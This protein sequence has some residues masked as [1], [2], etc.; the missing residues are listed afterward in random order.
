MYTYDEFIKLLCEHFNVFSLIN[1]KRIDKEKIN[2]DNLTEKFEIV[3]MDRNVSITTSNIQ[4]LVTPSEARAIPEFLEDIDLI[5]GEEERYNFNITVSDG[6]VFIKQLVADSLSIN[7]SDGDVYLENCILGSLSI[8]M[9]DGDT[10]LKNVVCDYLNISSEDGDIKLSNVASSEELRLITEDGN[11]TGKDIAAKTFVA[12]TNDGDIEV[13]KIV[14]D[15]ESIH[16]SDG[17]IKIKVGNKCQTNH[18]YSSDGDI[19][20]KYFKKKK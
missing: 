20:I 17:D 7:S 2:I 18:I 12:V 9:D 15:N 11:I 3:T 6:D 5:F 14:Y 8:E 13:E 19:K 1:N 16:T 4:E 10:Q